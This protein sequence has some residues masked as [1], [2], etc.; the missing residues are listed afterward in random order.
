MATAGY[1]LDANIFRL[2]AEGDV[3]TVERV[4]SHIDRVFLSSVTVE[5]M[6]V[7]RLNI[8]NRARGGKTPISL[9]ES[10]E[11]FAELLADIRPFPVL[12]YSSK[13][14]ARFQAFP[15][16]L[17]RRGPQDCRI[18]AQ[19]LAHGVTVVTRNRRDFEAIGA[20]CDDWSA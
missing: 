14:E 17:R 7:G 3:G 8:V 20:P 6:V 12:V 4:F 16:A 9:P 2:Y 15:A 11:E 19:A 10:H 5:E 1:L 13:A 18:A